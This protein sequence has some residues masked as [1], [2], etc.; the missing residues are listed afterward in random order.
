MHTNIQRFTATCVIALAGSACLADIHFQTNV[1]DMYQ[2]QKATQNNTPAPRPVGASY[3]SGD[4]WQPTGGWCATT[5]WV[6]ALYR[7]EHSLN[8]PKVFSHGNPNET[9]WLRQANYLNEELA[10]EASRSIPFRNPALAPN[11]ARASCI[12]PEGVTQYL[13]DRG[14]VSTIQKY[15]WDDAQ[16]AGQRVRSFT[17]GYGGAPDTYIDTDGGA[18]AT[19][20][21]GT[22]DSM[23]ELYSSLIRNDNLSVVI[24]FRS[25]TNRN[26]WWSRSNS[27]HQVTGAAVETVGGLNA[28]WFADPNDTFRGIGDYDLANNDWATE[29]F[30]YQ[31]TDEIPTHDYNFTRYFVGADGR[32]LSQ[33]GGA[34]GYADYNGIVIEEIYTLAIPAPGA[35]LLAALGGL[36]A[37]RRRRV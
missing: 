5:A 13:T 11:S 2:H 8:A 33:P 30:K 18:V 6:G 4:W 34:I 10:I 27:F 16:A 23:F 29:N 15:K 14:Y 20:S 32:T 17:T 26:T 19:P 31:G 36:L 12:S 3:D 9:N 37:A 24:H 35:G 25:G 28:I 7:A 22:Y 21:G 1:L